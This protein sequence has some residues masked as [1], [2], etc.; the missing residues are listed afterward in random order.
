[1][2]NF[3][4][5]I[6]RWFEGRY[7]IDNLFYLL[8]CFS[9][10]LAIINIFLRLIYLQIIVYALVIYAVFRAISKN[11]E[12]RRRENEALENLVNKIKRKRENA[13]LRKQDKTHIYKKCPYCKAVLK[14]PRIKGNH[15]TVCPRCKCEFNVRVY[16][17]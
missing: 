8:F 3:Y 13:I 6:M 5:K 15:K 4:Y 9:A 17:E 16:K 1:M 12:A 2:N 11:I 14:L 10:V 7:G